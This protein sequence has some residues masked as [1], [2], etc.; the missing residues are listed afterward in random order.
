MCSP[1]PRP[2]PSLYST[3]QPCPPPPSLGQAVHEQR[4]HNVHP[5]PR[6]QLRQSAQQ[7][8][9]R[10]QV[11]LVCGSKGKGWGASPWAG[12]CVEVARHSSFV[13]PPGCGTMDGCLPRGQTAPYSIPLPSFLSLP[14]GNPIMMHCMRYCCAMSSRQLTTCSSTL[15]ANHTRKQTPTTLV[16]ASAQLGST[17][18]AQ[19]GVLGHQAAAAACASRPG[20]LGLP[21]TWA[22]PRRGTAGRS[23]RPAG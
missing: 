9:Q 6:L 17:A 16:R 12:L 19:A 18:P 2:P 11:E 7:R 10:A 20:C 13:C 21:H 8:L 5:H 15:H 23:A 4:Q 3:A 22:V 1:A 14:P